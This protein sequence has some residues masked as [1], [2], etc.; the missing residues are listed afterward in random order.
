MTQRWRNLLD[1][2][3]KRV[4]AIGYKIKPPP[5]DAHPKASWCLVRPTGQILQHYQHE[6]RAITG[7]EKDIERAIKRHKT[8]NDLNDFWK[9][10]IKKV[11]EYDAAEPIFNKGQEVFITTLNAPPETGVVLSGPLKF[12]GEEPEWYR[13]KATTFEADIHQSRI[14]IITQEMKEHADA[15]PFYPGDIVDVRFNRDARD[16]YQYKQGIIKRQKET[17]PYFWFVEFPEHGSYCH[18]MNI[19]LSVNP[20]ID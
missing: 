13:V 10:V 6:A 18:R 2:R 1:L 11:Y 19:R 14:K 12:G 20:N 9:K 17:D 5:Q 8:H 15:Y 7:A 4:E 3:K 16:N